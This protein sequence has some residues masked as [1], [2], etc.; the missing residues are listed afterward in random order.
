MAELFPAQFGNRE[1]KSKIWCE[2]KNNKY[3]INRGIRLEKHSEYS[4]NIGVD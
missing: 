4:V 1:K 3:F 2:K